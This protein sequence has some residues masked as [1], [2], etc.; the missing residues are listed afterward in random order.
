MP[1]FVLVLDDSEI[2]AVITHIRNSWG[3]QAG[4][5]TSLQVQRVRGAQTR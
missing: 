5:I 1:P 3:N 2:A 4:G